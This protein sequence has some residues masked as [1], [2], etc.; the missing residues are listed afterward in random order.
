MMKPVHYYQ[1]GQTSESSAVSVFRKIG[2][3]WIYY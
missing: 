3:E 1:D 2:E